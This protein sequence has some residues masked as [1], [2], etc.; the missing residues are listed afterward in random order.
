MAK[1]SIRDYDSSSSNN[2]DVQ[3]VDISEGCS[4][5]GI[6][7]AIREVMADLADVN[8]GTIALE[9]PKFDSIKDGNIKPPDASGTDV[10]GTATTIKGG[11]GTGT[12]AGGSIVFQTADGG[13]TGSSVNA[14][15]TAMTIADDGSVGIGTSSPS[16]TLDVDGTIKLDGNYPVG[17]GNVALGD[18]ALDS[19]ASDGVQNTAIGSGA[20]TANTTGDNNVGVGYQALVANTTAT[21]NVAVGVNALLSNTTGIHNTAVGT[22]ALQSN[23]TANVNDAFGFQAMYSN[24]T[25]YYNA[26]YGYQS[27]YSNTTGFANAAYGFE[28]LYTQ[29]TSNSNNA[30]GYRAGKFIT[31]GNNNVC[32]GLQ[33][34]AYGTN[35]TTGTAN[36][37]IGNYTSATSGAATYANGLGYNLSCAAGYTTLGR[38]SLDIRAAHGNVTWSTVSDERYKKDIVDSTA[39]LSFINDLTPRTFKYRNL[40]ELPDTFDAYE[41]GSTEVFKNSLTNHG[42]I[43][44]EVKAVINAHPEIKD[45]FTMWDDRED[46]SQEVAEAALIPV[47][48]KAIQELSAK[49]DALETRIE[50]LENA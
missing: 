5:S 45:G 49:N 17:T 7:N 37:L 4:P 13:S 28:S 16:A 11:A 34:G 43:A 19:T 9:S 22:S 30:F 46:G 6:N 3:S 21:G 15:A 38:Q 47:L 48:V 18:T 40:G 31:T 20:L 1:N 39:G 2:S 41:E 29:T 33:A 25:G 27:M 32:I 50:A 42:F 35:L 44:Q 36:V 24:T 8:E 14:H 10:A 12:G 23:T 26:S